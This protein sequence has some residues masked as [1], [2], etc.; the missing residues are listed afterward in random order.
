MLL[1]YLVSWVLIMSY[2]NRTCNIEVH[3]LHFLLTAGPNLLAAR[4]KPQRD[5]REWSSN[6]STNQHKSSANFCQLRS[7]SFE[8]QQLRQQINPPL[9]R[10]VV[11]WLTQLQRAATATQV[12]RFDAKPGSG[13]SHGGL[14]GLADP[15]ASASAS[16]VWWV[17]TRPSVGVAGV[18]K[19]W[20]GEG[21]STW[22]MLV[23]LYFQWCFD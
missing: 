21:L 10:V 4:L 8:N 5:N 1:Q 19:R 11:P 3:P 13:S 18:G 14:G 12:R 23:M 22:L 15:C 17:G 2:I 7:N 16:V 6:K 20:L 9:L